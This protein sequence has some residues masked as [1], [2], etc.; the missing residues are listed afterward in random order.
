[1]SSIL[2]GGSPSISAL[3]LMALESNE[4]GKVWD[5]EDGPKEEIASVTIFFILIEHLV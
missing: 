3:V 1:M 2:V 4:H 5:P